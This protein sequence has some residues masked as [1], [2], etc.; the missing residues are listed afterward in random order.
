MQVEE[1]IDDPEPESEITEARRSVIAQ[2]AV[3]REGDGVEEQILQHLAQT[4]RISADSVNHAPDIHLYVHG[5]FVDR[6]PHRLN[7]LRH[8][9]GEIDRAKRQADLAAYHPR[10]VQ[11]VFDEPGLRLCTPLDGFKGAR[12]RRIVELTLT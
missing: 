2:P 6:G 3:R 1:L 8:E 11:H 9:G 5:F 10:N 4:V 7:R 12:A